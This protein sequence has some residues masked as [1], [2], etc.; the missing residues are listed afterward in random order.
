MLPV[1]DSVEVTAP[2]EIDMPYV[3]LWGDNNATALVQLQTCWPSTTVKK[4]MLEFN[5]YRESIEACNRIFPR[6]S[7]ITL[8]EMRMMMADPEEM[9]YEVLSTHWSQVKF[10]DITEMCFELGKNFNAESLRHKSRRGESVGT[11]GR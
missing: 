1:M 4:L 11:D 3:N 10:M 2:N 7:H 9:P 5:F 8:T 6:V